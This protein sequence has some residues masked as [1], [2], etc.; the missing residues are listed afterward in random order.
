M[1]YE[2]FDLLYI[3]PTSKEIF[4]IKKL[5]KK[6]NTCKN[7]FDTTVISES[8]NSFKISIFP[9]AQIGRRS[10]HEP[11]LKAF[12]FCIHDINIPE[13][14]YIQL[15][16]SV[17]KT[18]K[19]LMDMVEQLAKERNIKRLTLDCLATEYTWYESLGFK[20]SRTIFLSKNIPK[21]YH[22]IKLLN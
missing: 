19:L 15:V 7:E 4:N 8:I 5:I 1:N 18:G 22:M 16:C 14:I 17:N 11:I 13:E 10:F 12:I 3:E 20:Y 9:K 2:N 6:Y 21:V